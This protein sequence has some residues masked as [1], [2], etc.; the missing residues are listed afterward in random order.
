MNPRDPKKKFE[1]L[2]EKR[3]NKIIENLELIG[4]LSNKKNY[5][6]EDSQPQEI[7]RA[8]KRALKDAEE[9]FKQPESPKSRKFAF[10]K[11]ASVEDLIH[12]AAKLELQVLDALK[13]DPSLLK[14]ILEKN[15]AQYENDRDFY[16]DK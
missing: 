12:D 10:N 7:F 1:E 5:I 13:Q 3:T 15:L 6:Y 14:N 4:N 9:K 11:H 2:A 8:I 16:Q